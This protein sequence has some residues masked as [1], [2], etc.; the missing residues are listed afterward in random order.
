MVQKDSPRPSFEP[1]TS[2]ELAHKA[3]TNPQD[4]DA[5]TIIQDLYIYVIGSFT[6]KAQ[7]LIFLLKMYLFETQIIKHKQHSLLIRVYN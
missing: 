7:F 5:L 6:I 1:M 4:H 3:S 2:S